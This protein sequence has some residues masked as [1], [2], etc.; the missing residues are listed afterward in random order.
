MQGG[1]SACVMHIPTVYMA[2]R[3]SVRAVVVMGGQV[4]GGWCPEILLC[5]MAG[6]GTLLPSCI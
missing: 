2:L 1:A 3:V 4:E 6:G 5:A